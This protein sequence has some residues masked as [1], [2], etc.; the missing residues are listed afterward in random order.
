MHVQYPNMV[1]SPDA[2]VPWMEPQDNL[3]TCMTV[4]Y[5]CE[6]AHLLRDRSKHICALVTYYQMDSI[7]K[8]AHCKVKHAINLKLDSTLLDAGNLI[9]LFNLLTPL[10]CILGNTLFLLEYSKYRVVL[11]SGSL[12][13]TGCRVKLKGKT[14]IR[15]IKF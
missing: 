4:V 10:V 2:Y 3:W 12:Y 9:L 1:M 8:A 15:H 14:E 7:N 5:Y 6:K 11:H 13:M